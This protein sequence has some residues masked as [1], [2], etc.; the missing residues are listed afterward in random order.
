[1]FNWCA[2]TEIREN[3]NVLAGDL[4]VFG[5]KKARLLCFYLWYTFGTSTPSTG[6]L[7]PVT[8]VAVSVVLVVII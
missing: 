8:A 4:V 5:K 6:V 1:M 3:K 7:L 2:K